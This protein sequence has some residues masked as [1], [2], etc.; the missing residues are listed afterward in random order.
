MNE[1]SHT[2]QIVREKG[3]KLRELNPGF[4][5]DLYRAHKYPAVKDERLN[6]YRINY[7]IDLN[8]SFSKH[9]LFASTGYY[10]KNALLF[11]MEELLQTNKDFTKKIIDGWSQ[12][13]LIRQLIYMDFSD[14]FSKSF[15]PAEKGKTYKIEDI[16]NG[17]VDLD[18][19]LRWLFEYG[20]KVKYEDSDEIE[21]VP[22]DKSASMSRECRITFI[23]KEIKGELDKRLLL[24]IDFTN[25]KKLPLPQKD[26][27]IIKKTAI[28]VIPSKFYAYRGLYL[29]DANRVEQS[30]QLLFNEKSVV[31]IRDDEHKITENNNTENA[32]LF[33][34]VG[35][36]V[37]KNSATKWLLGNMPKDNISIKLT[38]FD[39]EGL[40]SPEYAH[41]INLELGKDKLGRKYAFRN[42]NLKNE[43]IKMDFSN[44]A[45][46]FQI[47]MPFIKG[48]LHTVDFCGFF[49][50]FSGT[51]E[52]LLI[53]DFFGIDR[54][55]KDAKI[56]LT[57]SM[58]KA[59]KWLN[60]FWKISDN[61][62][63]YTKLSE[64]QEEEIVTTNDPMEYFFG[65]MNEYHHALYVG[66]TNII[67]S[68]DNHTKMNYQFLNTLDMSGKDF[69]QLVTSHLAQV[70]EVKT[71]LLQNWENDIVNI[72]D[73]IADMS[74]EV[75][76]GAGGQPWMAALKKN[77]SF[78]NDPKIASMIS[79]T[80]D[81][82]VKDCFRGKLNVLGECRFLSGDLLSFL[83]DHVANLVVNEDT[84]K[85]VK[86]SLKGNRELKPLYINKF[87]MPQP[88]ISLDPMKNYG[89]LR[90]PHLSRNE[91]CALKPYIAKSGSAFDRYFSHL[92][93]VIMVARTS[94]VPMAL[95]GA[96]FDGDLVK[97]V[98]DPLIN[99]A[100]VSGTY[101]SANSDFETDPLTRNL[102]RK[103]PIIQIPDTKSS[104]PPGVD[105]GLIDYTTIKNT[106]SNSIGIISN[107]AIQIGKKE[108]V[109]LNSDFDGKSA[110]CTVVT[111]L[112]IDAAKTG[113]HPTRNIK[114][115]KE[116]IKTNE[117]REL[118]PEEIEEE[119]I[120]EE[121]GYER[122]DYRRVKEEKDY[123][124]KSKDVL[125]MLPKY[126]VKFEKRKTDILV[127]VSNETKERLK[128]QS[129]EGDDNVPNINRLPYRY[130]LYEMEKEHITKHDGN[131]VAEEKIEKNVCWKFQTDTD[132]VGKLDK[133]KKKE[134]KKVVEAWLKINGIN[135]KINNFRTRFKNTKYAGCV[136]TILQLQYDDV[137]SSLLSDGKTTV[138]E[139]LDMTYA[140]ITDLLDSPDKK[141]KALKKLI[142]CDWPFV[143]DHW[144]IPKKDSIERLLDI[145]GCKENELDDCIIELLT[146]F[147]NSGFKLLYYILKHVLCDSLADM[148]SDE[149]EEYE[150]NKASSPIE[151]LKDNFYFRG[152]YE[153][154]TK[155]MSVNCEKNLW[156]K[157]IIE[158]S[159]SYLD[160]IFDKD[161]KLAL[162]YVFSL[163]STDKNA[164]FFWRILW[165][166]ALIE[167]VY[168]AQ[169]GKIT[170]A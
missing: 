21:Y 27:N 109:E 39:G 139:A 112:E 34:E 37:D 133:E 170:Y 83:R 117:T 82:L 97:I 29:S 147:D 51:E 31:V 14:I 76:I 131:E 85:N 138:Q 46:S 116:S 156:E 25:Q 167:Q 43:N 55:L 30:E 128:I 91:Q 54:N 105:K 7:Q 95:S 8:E 136:Y 146:N 71:E 41:L 141:E 48:V 6:H 35:K 93:G 140:I 94:L 64:N 152:M 60:K 111:G 110:E 142:E 61:T 123:Y 100:I 66:N 56:I 79:G 84:R 127:K 67:L 90:S 102:R 73:D 28:T 62:L 137:Y 24:D 151:N 5:L 74:G 130:A 92:S 53:R 15:S 80:E 149:W 164:T 159:R 113:V 106:F 63:S 168:Y 122:R 121:M 86:N 10:R 89:I 129:F 70:N 12:E 99:T 103:L 145:L 38:P 69:E 153:K 3:Y 158:L 155:C 166:D 124:L 150:T 134:T 108:Y 162:A 144:P 1:S 65:K 11:Q 118:T 58:F 88:R 154:Y 104:F 98:A 59:C 169:G 45:S 22:F 126:G 16:E 75:L 77:E 81:S 4:I 57:E 47:R 101:E 163:R 18:T 50:E 120:R 40:I 19:Q 107:M 148:T 115:L 96:D 114:E 87:Y 143:S 165:E 36:T 72:E 52:S 23:N 9:L 32:P 161:H 132:W 13:S 157:E 20:F 68:D 49:E 160:S 78:I 42:P 17:E 44:E 135:S 2:I 125:S 33:G 119:N 26:D